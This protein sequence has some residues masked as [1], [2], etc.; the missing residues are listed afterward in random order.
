[1]QGTHNPSSSRENGI[2]TQQ[3]VLEPPAIRNVEATQE[4][5]KGGNPKT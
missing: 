1:M 5:G 2:K 3:L 4:L